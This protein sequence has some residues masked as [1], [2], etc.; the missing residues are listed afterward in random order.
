MKYR[1]KRHTVVQPLEESYRLIPLTQGQNAIVDTAD[2]EWL[3]RWNWVAKWN[4]HTRSF[5]VERR[6]NIRMHRL[7]LDCK[8][9]EQGDHRNHDTLDNRRGNLRKC[10]QAD[11]SHNQ[12]KR[13]NNKSG[14]KGVSYYG[15]HRIT[16]KWLACIKPNSK[17][18][19]IGYFDTPEEAARAYDK[20]AKKLFG[21]F[22]HLNF[23]PS[24]C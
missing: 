3:G 4:G 16:P 8:S 6:G 12:P 9:G 24:A 7:I 18:I 23:P 13:R 5:Y 10:T 2:F 1:V 19:S 15:W 20:V 21:E 22:A 11:N 17:S 14:F